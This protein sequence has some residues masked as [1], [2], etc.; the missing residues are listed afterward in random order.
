METARDSEQKRIEAMQ[1]QYRTVFVNPTEI[2]SE[3]IIQLLTVLRRMLTK[4]A[5]EGEEERQ[6]E[7]RRGVDGRVLS[8]LAVRLCQPKMKFTVA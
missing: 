2:T 4:S 8:W 6:A 3:A 5:K 7:E 1:Q